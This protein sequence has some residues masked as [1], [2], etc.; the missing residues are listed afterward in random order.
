M[1]CR[2][3]DFCAISSSS[4]RSWSAIIPFPLFFFFFALTCVLLLFVSSPNP[5]GA[6]FILLSLLHT[7][8]DLERWAG[9]QGQGT[10]VISGLNM[11]MSWS[12]C[13]SVEVSQQ[14]LIES[15]GIFALTKKAVLMLRWSE[16]DAS[17]GRK[18]E[19]TSRYYPWIRM[20]VILQTL[21]PST[22]RRASTYRYHFI[23]ALRNIHARHF[24]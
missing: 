5:L 15:G 1:F 8:K 23:T 17:V 4:V 7:S 6:A 13:S 19:G 3:L 9:P 24:L 18:G 14:S 16:M 21:P 20:N 11:V 22:H 2:L 12:F 10:L